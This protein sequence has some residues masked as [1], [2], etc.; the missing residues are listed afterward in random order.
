MSTP[1]LAVIVIFKGKAVYLFE[2]MQAKQFIYRNNN[3]LLIKENRMFIDKYSIIKVIYAL[4]GLNKDY[5]LSII[6]HRDV[7]V[8]SLEDK[9]EGLQINLHQKLN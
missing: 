7:Q 5:W 8:F 6:S 4:N 9:N 2:W 1:S 3:N